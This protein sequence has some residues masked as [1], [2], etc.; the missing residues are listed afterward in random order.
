MELFFAVSPVSRCVG[1]LWSLS[2]WQWGM[3]KGVHPKSDLLFSFQFWSLHFCTFLKENSNACLHAATNP[4]KDWE[5]QYH[6]ILC[7]VFSPSNDGE[8]NMGGACGHIKLE[9]IFN[10]PIHHIKDKPVQKAC[11]Q[12]S[13]QD[14]AIGG[15]FWI[16]WRFLI[17]LP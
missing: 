6:S 16:L 11:R 15:R 8:H 14:F 4:L 12:C 7:S 17:W 10:L 1:T 3:N 2:V 5:N 13:L 9:I